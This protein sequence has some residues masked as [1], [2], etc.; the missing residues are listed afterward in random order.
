MSKSIQSTESRLPNTLASGDEPAPSSPDQ[1]APQSAPANSAADDS[2]GRAAVAT[3]PAPT[4]NPPKQLPPYRVLLH[5]DDLNSTDYVIA[6]ICELTSLGRPRAV[7]T[8]LEA[9]KLGV[10]L[11]LVTHKERAELYQDQFHSKGLTVTI[12]PAEVRWADCR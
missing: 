5:N 9:D 11:V 12:E 1:N 2:G 6:T 7:L 8:T 10:S 4:R 3:R